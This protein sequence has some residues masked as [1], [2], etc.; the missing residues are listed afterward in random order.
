MRG[1]GSGYGIGLPNLVLEH[2]AL[3]LGPVLRVLGVKVSGFGVGGPGAV[4]LA[5]V[6]GVLPCLDVCFG[7]V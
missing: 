7:S 6:G 2:A 3:S 4:I 1:E 5:G